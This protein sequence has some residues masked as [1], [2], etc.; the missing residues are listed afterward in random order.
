MKFC[1]YIAMLAIAITFCQAAEA[2]PV[3]AGLRKAKAGAGKVLRRAMHPFK[4]GA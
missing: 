1:I 4:R 2:G 3:R